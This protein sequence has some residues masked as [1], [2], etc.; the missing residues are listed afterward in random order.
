MAQTISISAQENNS[1]G[2]CFLLKWEDDFTGE[3]Y[4]KCLYPM[5]DYSPQEA[6]D[7]F[8]NNYI[9]DEIIFI[10]DIYLL[11][12]FGPEIEYFARTFN[13]QYGIEYR[14]MS[15]ALHHIAI[16]ADKE[17]AEHADEQIF[18][19]ESN[20][21]PLTL[22]L[23]ADAENDLEINFRNVDAIYDDNEQISYRHYSDGEHNII[24]INNPAYDIYE[25]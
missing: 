11:D 5:S 8:I 4:D 17:S 10:E 23:L 14:N 13:C 2:T 16:Y 15:D 22:S 6:L 24:I 21:E 25:A 12:D 9:R 18:E 19:T 7:L 1:L 3:L 20:G